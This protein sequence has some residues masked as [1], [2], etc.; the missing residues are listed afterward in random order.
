MLERRAPKAFIASASYKIS[1]MREEIQRVVVMH[2]LEDKATLD[3]D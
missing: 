1:S 2:L 3:K